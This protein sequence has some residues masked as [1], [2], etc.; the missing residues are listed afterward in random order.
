MTMVFFHRAVGLLVHGDSGLRSVDLPHHPVSA[1]ERYEQAFGSQVRFDRDAALL[2]APVSL[3]ARTLDAVDDMLRTLALAYLERQPRMAGQVVTGR[4]RAILDQSLGTSSVG[5]VDVAKVM[6]VHPRA[7]QRQ[8]ASEGMA[9]ASILDEVRR[10]RARIYPDFGS[11]FA[12]RGDGRS[13]TGNFASRPAEKCA[14]TASARAR[15]WQTKSIT[16]R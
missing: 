9:F 3:L 14:L 13:L 2:R 11:R 8:L 16:S 6:A 5:L 4:V 7:L 10:A 12:T 15:C 1:V